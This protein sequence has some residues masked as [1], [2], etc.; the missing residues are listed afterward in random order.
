MAKRIA[1]FLV[2]L[3][4]LGLGTAGGGAG[5][6]GVAQG[7][8]SPESVL[9]GRAAIDDLLRGGRSLLGDI[10][11]GWRPL[12]IRPSW[13]SVAAGLWLRGEAIG[14]AANWYSGRI[15]AESG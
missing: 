15:A 5:G 1:L 12:I 9:A 14:R 2:V 8:V 11:T 13:R 3:S 10:G 4:L 7:A 6:P